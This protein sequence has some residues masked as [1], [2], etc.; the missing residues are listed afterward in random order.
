VGTIKWWQSNKVK[1]KIRDKM[2]Y[3]KERQNEHISKIRRLLV[4]KPEASIKDIKETLAGQAKPLVLD[5]DYINKLVNK[6]R[7]EKTKRLDY[8]TVN[9]V[10][11]DFQDE[12]AELKRRL[13]STITNPD[14]T[15]RDKISAIRELRT[16]SKDLFDKMFDAGVFNRKIG[17]ITLGNKLTAEEQKLLKDA[18]EM[19]YGKFDDSTTGGDEPRKVKPP[20]GKDK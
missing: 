14:S 5:K 4:I 15:D 17:E 6:I 1:R 20:L 9:K 12:V 8:Y 3:T 2:R 13:W 7:V 19:D 18:I 10:L 11:A 16:S